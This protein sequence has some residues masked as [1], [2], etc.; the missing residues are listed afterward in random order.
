MTKESELPEDEIDVEDGL[1]TA[2]IIAA[3]DWETTRRL[4]HDRDNW[5]NQHRVWDKELELWI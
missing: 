5:F 1:R 4:M 3:P 2:E